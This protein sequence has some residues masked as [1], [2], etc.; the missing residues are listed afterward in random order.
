MGSGLR[1]VGMREPG[2]DI[3]K[4][5][6]SSNKIVIKFAAMGPEIEEVLSGVGRNGEDG[7]IRKRV[8]ADDNG[9]RWI[10]KNW[11]AH[12]SFQSTENSDLNISCF[13]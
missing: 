3:V 9:K 8:Y 5:R 4:I 13:P 12:P 6:D 7:I 2:A 10:Y 1:I 11:D